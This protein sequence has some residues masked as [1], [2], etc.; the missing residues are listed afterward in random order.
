[1]GD[2]DFPFKE[3]I[4]KS[5]DDCSEPQETTAA[6]WGCVE[7]PE[8]DRKTTGVLAPRRSLWSMDSGLGIDGMVDRLSALPRIPV[9][10]M[11]QA[12]R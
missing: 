8:A 9:Q 3:R 11:A 5:L 7:D 10:A 12:G 2:R 6:P 4:E 1:M